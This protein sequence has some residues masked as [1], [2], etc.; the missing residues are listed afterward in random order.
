MENF[1]L[2]A[3]VIADESN[4]VAKF[5]YDGNNSFELVAYASLSRDMNDTS[6]YK[7]TV[8]LINQAGR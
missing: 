2:L 6:T 3:L 5:L 4:E 8:N 1:N 7:K